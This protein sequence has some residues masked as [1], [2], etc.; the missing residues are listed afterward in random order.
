VTLP[1]A[2]PHEYP[3]RFIERVEGEPSDRLAVALASAGGFLT[4]SGPWPLTLVAEAL[5]QAILL[6]RPPAGGG[7]LRLVA[8]DRV[9]QAQPLFAG[10]RLEVEVHELGAFGLLR[11]FSCYATRGGAFAAAAEITVSS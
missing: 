4:G 1:D 6:V 8:L 3:F 10:D 7:T 5:A 9:S 11:R 2:V